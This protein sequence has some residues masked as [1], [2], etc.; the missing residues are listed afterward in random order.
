MLK[1]AIDKAWAQIEAAQEKEK[2][3]R[4]QISK[5]KSDI[6]NL[7]RLVDQGASLSVGHQNKVQDLVNQ[8]LELEKDVLSCIRPLYSFMLL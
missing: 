6:Q 4:E 8:K 2:K 7:S 5:L 1:A 3:A